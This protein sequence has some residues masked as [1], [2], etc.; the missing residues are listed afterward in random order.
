MNLPLTS[1]ARQILAELHGKPRRIMQAIAAALD[2]QNELTVSHIKE[3]RLSGKG[4]FPASEGRLGVKTNRLRNSL[5]RSRAVISGSA[6][7]SAIGTNVEYAG[8][9]EFG[10]LISRKPFSGVVRLRTNADGSLLR[11]ARGG[12]R[13]AGLRHKRTRDA[14]F[15]SAG[16]STTMPARRPIGSG[17]E[18]KAPDYSR[19]ISD[20]IVTAWNAPT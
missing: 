12:A 8:I 2:T 18:D 20:A 10:G 17:I 5:R 15:S 9:H 7:D 14:A 19:R 11:N 1:N 6:V 16:H 4:P 3:K 13:F